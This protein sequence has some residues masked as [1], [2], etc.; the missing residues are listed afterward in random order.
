MTTIPATSAETDVV[1]LESATTLEPVSPTPV[2]IT[3]QEVMF[4]TAAAVA[5]PVQPVKTRGW[6]SRV[7]G[8]IVVAA[9]VTSNNEDQP[10]P[11]HYPRRNDFLESSRMAREMYRL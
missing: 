8:S 11:R 7:I 4:A 6:I 10:E 2:L 5:V 9:S 3:E 1:S